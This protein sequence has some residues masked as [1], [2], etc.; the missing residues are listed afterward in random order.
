VANTAVLNPRRQ[1]LLRTRVSRGENI[2][3]IVLALIL[4]AIV[5]WVLSTANDYD[6]ASRD[7]APELLGK[8]ASEQVLYPP[9]LKLLSDPNAPASAGGPVAALQPFP[10]SIVSDGWSLASR[11]RRFEAALH[12]VV[13]ASAESG[14]EIGI[15]LFDQ[16]D[17]GGSLGLFGD[18]RTANAEI[19]SLDGV[20]FFRTSIG[21]IG[22]RGRFFFRILGDADT[23]TVQTKAVQIAEALAALEDDEQSDSPAMSLLTQNLGF[24]ETQV[25]FQKA[26]VFKFDFASDF[27][28]AKT[29]DATD[30]RLFIHESESAETH[31]SHPFPAQ[32]PEELFCSC[33][34]GEMGSRC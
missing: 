8:A 19:E 3:V 23:E 9:P 27:W 2:V 12:Y 5:G 6:P 33:S 22:R 15:E 11:V 4:V 17:R 26:N 16:G 20:D 7:I 1:R 24:D 31:W 32:F 30:A 25:S 14:E 34:V 10:V 28:F 18:H 21:A 13:L 29:D